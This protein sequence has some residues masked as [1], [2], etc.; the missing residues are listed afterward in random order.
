M[1][2][3][4]VLADEEEMLLPWRLAD[5]VKCTQVQFL[6]MTASRLA[7]CF[8][9]KAFREAAQE[10]RLVIAGGRACIRGSRKHFGNVQLAD[11]SICTA[12]R[13]RPCVQRWRRFIREK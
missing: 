1:G 6:Q 8:G 2:N 7:L 13:R 9:N 12:R 5:L 10:L 11:W 4:V 3:Q